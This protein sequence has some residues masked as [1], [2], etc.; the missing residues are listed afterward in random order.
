LQV[1]ASA[2]PTPSNAPHWLNSDAWQAAFPHIIQCQPY[3]N[4]LPEAVLASLC[5]ARLGQAPKQVVVE[6]PWQAQ[7]LSEQCMRYAASLK[8]GVPSPVILTLGQWVSNDPA[9]VDETAQQSERQAALSLCTA[10]KQLNIDSIRSDAARYALAVDMVGLLKEID[11]RAQLSPALAFAGQDAGE[12]LSQSTWRS[13]EAQWLGVARQH[14]TSAG[15]LPVWQLR[16]Q[17]AQRLAGSSLLAAVFPAPHPSVTMQAFLSH[18]PSNS[19]A[20]I[21]LPVLDAVPAVQNTSARLSAISVTACESFEHEASSAAALIQ[22]VFRDGRESRDS[23]QRRSVVVVAHDRVLARRC[24]A[25]LARQQLPV[26]DRVGWAL[27]TTVAATVLRG[28]LTS[29]Q[30]SDVPALLAWLALPTVAAHWPHANEQ[31]SYLRQRWHQEPILPEGREFLSQAQFS[32][33]DDGIK[34]GLHAWHAAQKTGLIDKPLAQHALALQAYLSPLSAA[35]LSDAAGGKVWQQLQALAL[36]TESTPV[37]LATFI[38]V[39]DQALELERFSAS[40]HTH[41][42]TSPRIIFAPLYEAAWTQ[43]LPLVMLGCNEA[44]FPAAPRSP[45]QLL[46]SVR[47]ELGLPMPSAERAVWQHLLAQSNP[48]HAC[49][50]PSEQGNPSRL[51][52]WLLG[53]NVTHAP[54]AGPLPLLEVEKNTQAP[55]QLRV[56]HMPTQVS[57]TKLAAVLQCPYRFALQ[58]A[59]DIKPLSEPSVWPAQAERGNLLHEA[60]NHV[61]TDLQTLN[62]GAQLE[63]L[64]KAALHAQLQRKEKL[65]G[66]YGA[67]VADSHRTLATF[68]AAHEA[69]QIEGWRVNATEHTI[70]SLQL[71]EGVNVHGKIDRM[72]VMRDN[73]SEAVA[74]AVLDYKTTNEVVLKKKVKDVTLDAQ[75]AL[76][77]LLAELNELPPAQAAYWRLHDGLHEASS[78][79]SDYHSKKTVFELC[80]LPTEIAHVKTAVRSAWQALSDTQHAAAMPSPESCQYCAYKTVCRS[81]HLIDDDAQEGSDE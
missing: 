11:T 25:L 30:G 58:A 48:I 60:L 76:Y 20:W 72:D 81:S 18:L 69:R 36:E 34:R 55:A 45:S 65:S 44:H 40:T 21:G 37:S 14:L 32:A 38:A 43:G 7:W 5:S 6:Q 71:I 75:L 68:N 15:Q 22:A 27:S 33:S 8:H 51:S 29:W 80:E 12:R 10:L 64:I 74:Y 56:A 31:L 28:V 26:E 73:T 24:A 19:S 1:P 62:H 50:T 42:A 67:L 46:S 54:V 53:A 78:V 47:R 79:K 63:R 3:S 35:L 13:R 57:V 2:Q 49:F 66:R 4:A 41:D 9:L 23:T 16:L 59:F 61:K 52:P 39:L 70:E 77:A 17:A